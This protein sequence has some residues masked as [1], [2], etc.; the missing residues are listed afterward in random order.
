MGKDIYNQLKPL[1]REE[2]EFTKAQL[3][4]NYEKI[5]PD[6]LSALNNKDLH[7]MFGIETEYHGVDKNKQPIPNAGKAVKEI[8]P[9][10]DEDCGGQMLELTSSPAEAN[11]G[12]PSKTLEDLVKK[13]N[14]MRNDFNKIFDSHPIPI[15]LLPTFSTDE[16][17]SR[18]VPERRRAQLINPY[19]L[20]FMKPEDTVFYEE[21]TGNKINF[22]K[23]PGGGFM[24]SLHVSVSASD[25]R[26][27]VL[28]Y[29]I[30]NA[31]SGPMVA[32]AAN[33]CAADG[34]LTTLED[35]H[36][37]VYEKNKEIVN[38][39]PR[40]GNFPEY[41]DSL[42][43]YFKKMLEFNPIFK[44]DESAPEESL[45][46]HFSSTWP[47]VKAQVNG[48]YRVEFRPMPKQPTLL[49]DVAVSSF[50]LYSLL[51]LEEELGE[52]VNTRES[53]SEYCNKNLF[54]S[55]YLIKNTR[56]AAANG[57][58]ARLA[59]KGKLEKPQKILN[60]LY[61]KAV[62]Y[63]EKHGITGDDYEILKTA[64]PRIENQLNPSR[65]FREEVKKNGFEDALYK[66][67]NHTVNKRDKP[68]VG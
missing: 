57:F 7:P 64:K 1:D 5:F 55:Q 35:T 18:F 15:G 62:N 41:M 20:E 60:E 23:V 65:K 17:Y 6:L 45:H 44:F 37:F 39:V 10:V 36:L 11:K 40:V 61:S 27:S 8:N 32:L 9:D 29:N 54:P 53:I 51:A 38:G 34:K 21:G 49:E 67:H 43:D 19:I 59:W 30:A 50:F 13:E 42:N 63:M 28:L 48:F 25:D 14:R 26:H 47:W 2:M 33:S 16:D 22:G 4:H 46:N 24:N 66:Y 12:G 58:D 68:Y 31:L 52:I 3:K 56:E